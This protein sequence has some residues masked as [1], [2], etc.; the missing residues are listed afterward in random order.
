MTAPHSATYRGTPLVFDEKFEEPKPDPSAPAT[1]IPIGCFIARVGNAVVQHRRQGK[2]ALLLVVSPWL[3]E[4]LRGAGRDRVHGLQVRV[5]ERLVGYQVGIT[6]TMA[7]FEAGLAPPPVE[8][9]ALEIAHQLEAGE[10]VELRAGETI[11]GSSSGEVFLGD[12]VI[13]Q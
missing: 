10:T 6:D 5:H 11:C 8:N 7:N 4:Q 12:K 13:P 9:R 3:G 1:T 2:T